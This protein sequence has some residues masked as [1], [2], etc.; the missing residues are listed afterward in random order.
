MSAVMHFGEKCAAGST[1]RVF[2]MGKRRGVV[3]LCAPDLCVGNQNL[4][5]QALNTAW[6]GLFPPYFVNS[7]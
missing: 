6:A 3:L 1:Q 2:A 5:S 7:P 4:Y